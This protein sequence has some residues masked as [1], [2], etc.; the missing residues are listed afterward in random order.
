VAEVD[1]VVV[2][3]EEEEEE[4]TVVV[5]AA[6]EVVVIMAMVD[7]VAAIVGRCSPSFQPSVP[8]MTPSSHSYMTLYNSNYLYLASICLCARRVCSNYEV[9]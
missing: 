8:L 5:E 9:P 7:E 6:T 2:V 3:V 4:V 1:E